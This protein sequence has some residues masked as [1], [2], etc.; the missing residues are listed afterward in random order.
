MRWCVARDHSSGSSRYQPRVQQHA[1]MRSKQQRAWM[2]IR[3]P[4]HSEHGQQ[5]STVL[6]TKHVVVVC[7]TTYVLCPACLNAARVYDIAPSRPSCN[8]L[9]ARTQRHNP[10]TTHRVGNQTLVGALDHCRQ[11]DQ[12][13]GW[14]TRRCAAEGH[15]LLRCR[16]RCNAVSTPLC[17]TRRTAAMTQHSEA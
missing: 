15:T 11:P 6:T 10:N 5:I 3:Q 9:N 17:D 14:R 7:T 1:G 4:P 16:Q 12:R 13:P 2:W 8:P